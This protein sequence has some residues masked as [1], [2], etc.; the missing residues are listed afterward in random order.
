MTVAIRVVA[1][2]LLVAWVMLAGWC[3]AMTLQFLVLS[4]GICE[5]IPLEADHGEE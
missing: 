1:A 4:T 5:V 3:S 2:V